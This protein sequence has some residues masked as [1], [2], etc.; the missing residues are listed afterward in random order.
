MANEK[1]QSLPP[2]HELKYYMNPA[3]IV[4][5]RS[6]LIGAMRRDK[7]TGPEG[8]YA[9]R[10]LYFDDAYDS[11]WDEK[12]AGVMH[13]DKYRIRI[14]N[15]SDSVIFMERKR[16]I[17]DL[18]AKSSVRITRRLAEQIISGDPTGLNMAQNPLIQ[19]VYVMMRTRVLRPKVIVDYRRE[20]FVH[21]AEDTRVTFDTHICAAGGM[22]DIFDPSVP[23]VPALPDGR[24]VLEVKYDN[25]LPTHIAG[26]LSDIS[27]ERSAV[28][29][30]ILCRRYSM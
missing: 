19:D 14:Y 23:T 1:R 20:A 22:N 10:S 12:L 16:K 30:Y 11:A 2:R 7:H 3:E 18:I 26:L 21:P 17:G 24:E 25:Y 4:A 13:R 15:Y 9:I 28:S 29:K 6:R 8:W 27:C 5:L